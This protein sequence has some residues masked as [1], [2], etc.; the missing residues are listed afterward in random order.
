[1]HTDKVVSVHD[2]VNESIQHNGEVHISIVLSVGVK[3]VEQKDGEMMVDVEER[4]LPP[5][6]S[7]DNEN[8]IPEIPNL[9]YVK[10]PEEVSHGRILVIVY[11]TDK[12]VSVAVGD[13]ECFDGHVCTE[14]DLGN[15]VD[16]LDWV[17]VHGRYSSL[18]NSRSDD[19]ESDI[20]ESNGDGNAELIELPALRFEQ[21]SKLNGQWVG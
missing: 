7:K 17:G 15:V 10:E 14:E 18:H 11:V 20:S 4:K 12:S 16:E 6:L 9:G 1:M 5:L 3:P 21:E 19:D 2:S 13:Q 8:G